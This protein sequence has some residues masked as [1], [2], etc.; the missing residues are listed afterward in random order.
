M[1]KLH[2]AINKRSYEAAFGHWQRDLTTGVMYTMQPSQHCSSEMKAK[3]WNVGICEIAYRTTFKKM[4][5]QM[6]GEE[7]ESHE[8]RPDTPADFRRKLQ[9]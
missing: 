2:K 8:P 9:L 3:D 7:Q 5:E 6:L 4:C 1:G